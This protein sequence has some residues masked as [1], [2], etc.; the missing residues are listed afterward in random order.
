MPMPKLTSIAL[1][2]LT[3]GGEGVGWHGKFDTPHLQICDYLYD[4]TLWTFVMLKIL[5]ICDAW[6]DL[7]KMQKMFRNGGQLKSRYN[8]KIDT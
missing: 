1:H 5:E 3:L 6:K 2:S 4:S 8:N 7:Q